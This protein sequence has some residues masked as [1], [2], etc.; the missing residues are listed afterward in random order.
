MP[1]NPFAYNEGGL[2]MKKVISIVLTIV[3]FMAA[4]P[5]LA[6][7]LDFKGMT[8]V[9]DNGYYRGRSDIEKVVFHENM[10]YIGN[11]A[12]EN[13]ENLKEV[14]FPYIGSIELGTGVFRNCKSL[15]EITL[16]GGIKEMKYPICEGCDNLKTVN[17]GFNFTLSPDDKS[18][19]D[20]P[21]ESYYVEEGNPRYEVV[22]RVLIDKEKNEP[23]NCTMTAA[24]NIT[25]SFENGV[26]T[27][28]GFG[29]VDKNVEVAWKDTVEKLINVS[30]HFA[31]AEKQ[32]KKV[33]VGKDISSIEHITYYMMEPYT[34]SY[35]EEFE[36]HPD[37]KF[38]SS[39]DGVLFNKDKTKLVK[40]PQGK[41]MEEYIVP[42]TVKEFGDGAFRECNIG[43]V[44]L[45]HGIE[46]LPSFESADVLKVTIPKSVTEIAPVFS[47]N[48]S[49]YDTSGLNKISEIVYTGS[50]KQW[51]DT[52]KFGSY[53]IYDLDYTSAGNLLEAAKKYYGDKFVYVDGCLVELT[54]SITQEYNKV[55]VPMRGICEALGYTVSWDNKEGCALAVK[56]GK[57]VKFPVLFNTTDI[58][59]AYVN[60]KGYEVKS[61]R[62]YTSRGET[63]YKKIP[64][65]A[66]LENGV[67][68]ISVKAIDD[69]F[70][71]KIG[72]NETFDCMSFTTEGFEAIDIKDYIKTTEKI[73]FT[74]N[75]ERFVN[76]YEGVVYEKEDIEN[77]LTIVS[78]MSILP[79]K[80]QTNWLP[81]GDWL[82][83][84]AL[85]EDV[86]LYVAIN[87]DDLMVK[88]EGNKSFYK[89]HD[90]D[91]VLQK[92]LPIFARNANGER[93]HLKYQRNMCSVTP[94]VVEEKHYITYEQ[95]MIFVKETGIKLEY[96]L[97]DEVLSVKNAYGKI[98][99][100]DP[101]VTEGG[102]LYSL[103]DITQFLMYHYS[104]NEKTGFVGI[105]KP[106]NVP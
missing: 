79:D 7:E 54:F 98:Q 58:Y 23:V 106:W 44:V 78:E 60:G 3:L 47:G 59:E 26:L 80:A 49:K 88:S 92:L 48:A 10:T 102:K 93:I 90:W 76:G 1:I 65:R 18:L 16:A 55:M 99:V 89:I 27:I 22:D 20:R 75:G 19:F 97:I 70:G 84:T 43:H 52:K 73:T 17:I 63:L 38:Y 11:R 37:N 77:I 2:K 85:G 13:C 53:N 15:T 5:V 50:I 31:T 87:K 82:S 46:K 51:T 14:E 32:T 105:I 66:T 103:K 95:L 9:G 4:V 68:M 35:V 42:A 33:I 45:P 64:H 57:E 29:G 12:F 39:E 83:F 36:V 74:Y 104:V 56:E 24:D 86:E 96:T 62:S 61:E 94:F 67:T 69:I 101:L 100:I 72:W 28:D 40:F 30:P 21:I 6:E 81:A 41:V 91:I 8:A 34:Y 25:W 71:V